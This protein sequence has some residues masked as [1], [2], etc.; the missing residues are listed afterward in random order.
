MANG[1]IVPSHGIW[2]G[3]IKFGGVCREGQ[4]EVF[5]SGGAWTMLFGKPLLEEFRMIQDYTTDELVVPTLEGGTVRIPNQ[6]HHLSRTSPTNTTRT[7]VITTSKEPV[8]TSETTR[9]G[10]NDPRTRH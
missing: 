10:N 8:R 2:Q 9:L 6:Y 5:P 3:V 4:F 7:A 1:A